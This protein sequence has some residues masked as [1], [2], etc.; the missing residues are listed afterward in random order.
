MDVAVVGRRLDYEVIIYTM[1]NARKGE[2]GTAVLAS[3]PMPS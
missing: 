1:K 2:D 3:E